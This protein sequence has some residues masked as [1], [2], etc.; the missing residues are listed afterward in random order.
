[1]VIIAPTSLF[2]R[3]LEL[4]AM[5]KLKVRLTR[6]LIFLDSILCYRHAHDYRSRTES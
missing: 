4:F 6:H 1:M 2:W 3:V 5:T